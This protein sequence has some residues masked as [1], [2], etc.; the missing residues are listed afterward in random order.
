MTLD[1]RR[2]GAAGVLDTIWEM[3]DGGLGLA[4]PGI[5]LMG[6]L[7]QGDPAADDAAIFAACE[8][9]I[10]PG[11]PPGIAWRMLID[12]NGSLPRALQVKLRSDTAQALRRAVPALRFAWIA[13][14]L[15]RLMEAPAP[16]R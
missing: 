14:Q 5:H 2:R 8:E 6:R 10:W 9:L 15:R 13:E 16:S 3:G 11:N 12:R 7:A 1:C 4:A